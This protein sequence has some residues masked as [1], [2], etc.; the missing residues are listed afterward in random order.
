MKKAIPYIPT[1]SYPETVKHKN[2][3]GTCIFIMH[4][5]IHISSIL[6]STT[7]CNMYVGKIKRKFFVLNQGN[8]KL[9]YTNEIHYFFAN[10]TPLLVGCMFLAS[11]Q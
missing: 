8:Y 11:H 1:C 7:A 10:Q 2:Q 4:M 6:T 5:F 3:T 9:F